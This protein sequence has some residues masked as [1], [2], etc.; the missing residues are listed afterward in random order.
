MGCKKEA[1][2]YPGIISRKINILLNAIL[3]TQDFDKLF[4]CFVTG[5]ESAV[6]TW[7]PSV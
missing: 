5:V 6:L 7:D 1:L 4:F 2:C 3:F